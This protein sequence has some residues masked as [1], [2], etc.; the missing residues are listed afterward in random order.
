MFWVPELSLTKEMDEIKKAEE[1][2]I[3]ILRECQFFQELK[4]L[5]LTFNKDGEIALGGRKALIE[6]CNDNEYNADSIQI[7]FAAS[8]VYYECEMPEHKNWEMDKLKCL[9]HEVE[10]AYDLNH[11]L[12]GGVMHSL[13]TLSPKLVR[14]SLTD[15][16]A[17]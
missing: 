2:L 9:I 14:I 15:Y 5:C 12:T 4:E 11:W 6:E 3:N 17:N 1:L 16:R 10:V 7:I 13:S 8:S